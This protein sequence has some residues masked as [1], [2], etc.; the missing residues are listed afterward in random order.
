LTL[1]AL[2]AAADPF[3]QQVRPVLEANCA[4]CHNPKNAKNRIDFLKAVKADDVE[5]RRGLWRDVAIQLRNRTMPPVASKLTEKDR[6]EV[7]QWIETRLKETAC[8]GGEYAGYVAPRRLN[9]REYK[10]T[11]RDLFGV[12]LDIAQLFPEDESGGAGFDTNG[13]TLYV[14]PMMMERYMEAAQQVVDRIVF[15]PPFSKAIP[16][17]EMEPALA[18]DKPGRP[19][20]PGDSLSTTLPLFVSGNYNIRLSVERQGVPLEAE[21]FVDGAMVSRLVYQRDSAGGPTAR[22][23]VMKL[24]RGVHT[25]RTVIGKFPLVFY[26]LMVDQVPDPLSFEK[27][28]LHYRLFGTEPGDG[29]LDPEKST[30]RMLEN[31]LPRAFRHPADAADIDSYMGLYRRSAERGDPHEESV[32]LTLK[33]VLVSPKFLFRLER[34]PDGAGIAPLDHFDVASRLSYL[35]WSAPPDEELIRLASAGKLR[36]AAELTRQVDRMLDD[37]R[38]RMLADAFMG[39]WLGTKDVGGRVV[40]LLT[41]LQHYYTPEAA[42]ELRQEPALLFQHLASENRSLL[43]LL[44]AN[45]A[46][47]TER[48]ARFYQVEGKVAGL[49]GDS[50]QKVQWPDDRRAGILGMASVLAMTSHYRQASPVLRGAWVLDT[51]L[52]TPVP[53]PPPDVPPLENI[54]RTEKGLTMRQVLARHRAD[55]ACATCHNLMDP[56]GFGLENFDWMG[57]W[58]D[59]ESNGQPVDASGVM[60]S[61]ERFSGPVELRN[62]LL[63]RK[64][65]FLRHLTGKMMGFALGRSLRDEDWCTV[66]RIGDALEEN[67]YAAR[68]LLKEIVLSPQFLNTQGGVEISRDTPGVRKGPKRLLG[69]K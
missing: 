59:T 47:L 32:K 64:T 41:E 46:F 19:L 54:T 67:G 15:T 8:V 50:F 57:R 3:Q 58:R 65:D 18:S 23:L 35:L 16:S 42:A 38:S 36:D 51:I 21:L 68:T 20:Q 29:M 44:N 12:D 56:I 22:G 30:R 43:E 4:A 37:P 62:M 34:A 27:R 45:Y 31:L 40:P 39:Q 61:G 52:G 5:L 33:A 49:R 13:E 66:Q 1:A 6:L 69:D 55:P 63:A 7:A 2:C 28:Y 17:S 53:P 11:I 26:R 24:D 14:P 25:I 48:L 60:P 9:R 10:N